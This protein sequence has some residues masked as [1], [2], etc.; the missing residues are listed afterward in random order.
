MDSELQKIID[1]CKDN[2]HKAFEVVYKKFYRILLGVAMRYTA[3][4]AEAEDILQDSYI[5]IFHSIHSFA[6]KG[7]FEGWMKRIVQNT[8]INSCRSKLKFELYIELSEQEEKLSDTGFETVLGRLEVK[9]IVTL[10]NGMPEGYRLAINLYF[11]DGYTHREIAAMLNIS[12]GTSKSQLF[13]AKNYLKNLLE[14]QDKEKI[15]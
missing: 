10:L 12:E 2:D 9:D 4:Y 6:Y 11:I 14:T 8:A 15:I 1:K 7:S 13:R 5:K 3:N